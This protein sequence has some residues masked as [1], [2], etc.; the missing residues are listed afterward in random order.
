[1]IESWNHLTVIS[2]ELVYDIWIVKVFRI[3]I[4]E[5]TGWWLALTEM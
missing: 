3:P 4:E 2:I 1:M 5:T